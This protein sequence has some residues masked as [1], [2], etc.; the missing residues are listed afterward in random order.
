[1]SYDVFSLPKISCVDI[2]CC[3][4]YALSC[5]IVFAQTVSSESTST[6]SYISSQGLVSRRRRHVLRAAEFIF[7]KMAW[8][9]QSSPPLVPHSVFRRLR[10]LAG[11]SP[12]ASNADVRCSVL[13]ATR[14][15]MKLLSLWP[16]VFFWH[17]RHFTLIVTRA[18]VISFAQAPWL[19]VSPWLSEV[20]P[21]GNNFFHSVYL[22]VPSSC[23]F[24]FEHLL[25]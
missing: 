16:C 18:D 7:S 24:V 21:D 2:L 23:A 15:R 3:N 25:T 14:K 8:L 19:A 5:F 1:M 9:A 6:C 10:S 4:R 17:A 22:L 20:K 13:G 12:F 11:E